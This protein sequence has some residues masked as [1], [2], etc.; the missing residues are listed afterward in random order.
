MAG[1]RVE[2]VV[3]GKN[4][5]QAGFR[6]ARE[7]AKKLPERIEI[8]VTA[9]DETEAGIAS[10]RRGLDGLPNRVTV[11]IT[12]DDRTGDTFDRVAQKARETSK[13]IGE[14][15]QDAGQQFG[16]GVTGAA[17]NTLAAGG[18]LLIGGITA[19]TLVAAPH[20]GSI[21]AG[22]VVGSATAGGGILGGIYA[23]VRHPRVRVAGKE[24]WKNL[25]GE[26]DESSEVMIEPLLGVFDKVDAYMRG[27]GGDMFDSL[28]GNAAQVIGPLSRDIIDFIDSILNGIDAMMERSGPVMD[29]LS[30]GIRLLGD[31]IEDFFLAISENGEQA[32]ENLRII[33]GFT[34]DLISDFG[35]FLNVLNEVTANPIFGGGLLDILRERYSGLSE[36]SDTFT[37]A[38][39]NAASSLHKVG[40]EA[41]NTRNELEQ[42]SDEMRAQTDPAFALLDA[43]N[44]LTDAQVRYNKAVKEHGRNSPEAREALRDVTKAAINA[45]E[46]AGKLGDTFKGEL[47]PSMKAT[48]RAAGLTEQQIK[49][50]TREMR[51]SKDVAEDYAGNYYVTFHV[52][53]RGAI[54]QN[55]SIRSLMEGRNYASGGIV[56]AQPGI[57]GAASGGVRNGMTWVGEQGPELAE[58]PPGTRVHP[59]GQSQRM[60]QEMSGGGGKREPVVLEL[61]SSGNA[62]DDFLLERLRESIRVQGGDVQIVLGT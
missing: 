22:A 3:V 27:R 20:L 36:D 50:V 25:L 47:T 7:D 29:G 49:D 4:D 48:L 8:T 31:G 40:K 53:T 26:L 17:A 52:R 51:R 32:G 59:A 34:A 61:R 35:Q 21:I 5:T 43:Q 12:A 18:P 41:A 54:P 9:E 55:H 44:D 58:L 16:K 56:G 42:L 37:D 39:K 23:G 15:G 46:A 30:D 60:A 24:L 33:L 10:A 38:N 57:P 19:A 14:S 28:F 11:T 45:T 13:K 2:I 6:A 1:N 62:V